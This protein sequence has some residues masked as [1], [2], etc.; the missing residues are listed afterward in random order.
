MRWHLLLLRRPVHW[1]ALHR[2]LLLRRHAPHLLLLG[3][4]LWVGIH[5]TRRAAHWLPRLAETLKHRGGLR[6]LMLGRHHRRLLRLHR[7]QRRLTR[8]LGHS[9]V[10]SRV[11]LTRRLLHSVQRWR[12][13]GGGELVHH[14]LP[15]RD[16]RGDGRLTRRGLLRGRR[17]LL[18]AGLVARR[19]TLSRGALGRRHPEAQ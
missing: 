16:R 15:L 7:T 10:H 12:H 4:N 14:G 1:L 18:R 5:R 6:G 17:V 13:A 11:R 9:R 8:L 3:V 2:L 19:P